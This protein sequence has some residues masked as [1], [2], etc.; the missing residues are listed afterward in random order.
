MS[1]QPKLEHGSSPGT[2]HCAVPR[3]SVQTLPTPPTST[4]DLTASASDNSYDKLMNMVGP[5][6][7]TIKEYMTDVQNIRAANESHRAKIQEIVNELPAKEKDHEDKIEEKVQLTVAIAQAQRL[8]D[9]MKQASE[10]LVSP[11]SDEGSN[12]ELMVRMIASQN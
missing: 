2:I 6:Q 11:V 3:P 12:G 4:V 5:I 1:V 8:V 7:Q 9:D 10:D